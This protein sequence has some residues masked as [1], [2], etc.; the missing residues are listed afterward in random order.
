M[1]KHLCFSFTVNTLAGV[2]INWF[3]LDRTYVCRV[4][5]Y[6][7]NSSIITVGSPVFQWFRE[8]M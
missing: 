6:V 8:E 1:A 7:D 5:T 4:D 3:W 2:T